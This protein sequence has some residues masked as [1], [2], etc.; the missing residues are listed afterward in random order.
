MTVTQ[1][2][3]AISSTD[4]GESRWSYTSATSDTPLLGLT[5]GDLFDQTVEKYPENPALIARQ[6]K[7]R[8]SYREL[9]KEVNQCAKGLMHLG[10]QKGQR[11]GIWSPNRAEWCVT[12][13]ATSKVGAIL[14][15]LNPSYRLHELEYAL[16]QSGCSAIVISPEFKTSNY[17]EM[18]NTL[19]PELKDSEPGAL[20]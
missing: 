11:V 12:Q 13:F 17:T 9:Q 19:A 20:K 7:I 5:I 4:Q 2:N 6:Q 8:L 1:K 10:L 15:N 3:P 14:V 16:T 18:V